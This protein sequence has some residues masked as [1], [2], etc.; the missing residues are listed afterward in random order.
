MANL[1][2]YLLVILVSIIGIGFVMV[3]SRYIRDIKITRQ[4]LNKWRSQLVETR[5]GAIEYARVGEGYPILVVHGAFGGYDQGLL[6]TEYLAKA[7]FQIIAISRFG[8]LG[9]PI[10]A[11]PDLNR[12]SDTYACLLDELGIQ[13]AVIYG[14]SGGASS[15]I[16]FAARYP[17]RTALLVL[18]SPA[19][20]GD[21]VPAAPPKAALS[22]MGSDFVYWAMVTYLRPAVQTFMG[23]P[24][25]FVL[26]PATDAEFASVLATTLPSNRRIPGFLNDFYGMPADEFFEEIKDNNPYSVQKIQ[27]PTLVIHSLD[28]PLAL[29][30]NVIRLSDLIPNAHRI[31]LPDGGHLLLGHSVEIKAEVTRFLL[32]NGTKLEGSRQN[33]V[34]REGE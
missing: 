9:S 25:R 15:A 22:M 5:C 23:V 8:Y 1:K 18:Q 19:A 21:V 7:G 24:K 28:D 33:V 6:S 3:G 31:A 13:Q 29:P 30:E 34:L 11:S 16:R 26:T 2:V 20:P 10:P 27:A 14:I 12:Q 32:R 4:A 17:K